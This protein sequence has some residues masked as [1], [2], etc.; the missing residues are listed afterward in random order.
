MKICSCMC[1]CMKSVL[2]PF[3]HTVILTGESGSVK[4][5]YMCKGDTTVLTCITAS[6]YGFLHWKIGNVTCIFGGT[7][8]K[9]D[10][11]TL[12][13]NITLKL[14][15]KEKC[16][17][18]EMLYT[19]TA[20]LQNV[21]QRKTVKCSDSGSYQRHYSVKLISKFTTCMHPCFFS[22]KDD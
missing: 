14:T 8:N 4:H 15:N 21:H 12:P 9:G 3:I 18:S 11:I 17:S 7:A 20:T 22:T 6:H 1:A 10:V 13:S 19:S 16:S 5:V 2:F